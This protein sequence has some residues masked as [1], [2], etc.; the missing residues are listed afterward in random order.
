MQICKLAAKYQLIF[1]PIINKLFII[2]N[3]ENKKY[4]KEI[5]IKAK[6]IKL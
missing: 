5:E 3:Y 6:A 4:V 1:N 2:K